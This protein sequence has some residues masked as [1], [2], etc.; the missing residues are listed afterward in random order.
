MSDK[1]GQG[2]FSMVALMVLLFLVSLQLKVNYF[3]MASDLGSF[4][5]G[6]LG[7]VEIVHKAPVL[8][9]VAVVISFSLIAVTL[10]ML[11]VPIIVLITGM[12]KSF[13][14][15]ELDKILEKPIL[16]FGTVAGEELF[17]R[18]LFLGFLVSIFTG[19]A[20]FY[21]L[22]ITGNLLWA[23]LHLLNYKNENERKFAL[24]LPQFLVG[25]VFAFLF[26]KFGFWV[27]LATH[28]TYDLILF[29]SRKKS[30]NP[31]NWLFVAYYAIVG[32]VAYY[33]MGSRGISLASF[34]PWLDGEAIAPITNFGFWDYMIPLIFLDCVV[35]AVLELIRLDRS[36]E[37]DEDKK[38]L[39]PLFAGL[40][41]LAST[42]ILFGE[43]WI[44]S[45]FVPELFHR[46]VVIT[47][48]GVVLLRASSGSDLARR[49]FTN[50]PTNYLGLAAFFSLG[51]WSAF[52]LMVGFY[53]TS[54]IPHTIK[55]YFE[56]KAGTQVIPAAPQKRGGLY[57]E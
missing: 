39:N 25:L 56:S 3:Q 5:T 32:F 15:E 20:A 24:I 31:G 45:F 55:T 11:S 21:I 9:Q 4:L 42:A 47:L 27:A 7:Q 51:F 33:L 28:L 18:A 19:V 23:S 50:L 38:M 16:F 40:T 46:V 29:A 49:Y 37:T 26:Y 44:L 14:A 48:T 35:I 10:S 1:N 34:T 22:M 8:D 54:Y 30:V 17:A 12:P 2:T 41:L 13:H 43:N 57:Q 6:S 52:F 53:V 36:A